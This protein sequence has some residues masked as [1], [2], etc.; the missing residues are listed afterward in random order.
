MSTSI[1]VLKLKGGKWYVGKSDNPLKRYEQHLNGHGSS[2]TK[3]YSPI[4]LE[5]T[6]QNASHFDEDKVTKEYM[7][8]YGIDNV[9]G[10][11]YCSV[12][13]DD[14]Q[15]EVLNREIWGA[16]NKCTR[17]GRST[18]FVKDCYAKTDVNGTTLENEIWCCETCDTEFE[19][20]N[21]CEKHEK[22]CK[23]RVS[24]F[25]CGREG[26]ISTM[27]YAKTH[28]RGYYLR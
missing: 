10:G 18:H 15:M 13:L 2:W 21:E 25:R 11:S 8:K 19:D 22:F 27:C 1:Y 28:I 7:A 20:K 6:I 24:C 3:L 23:K 12:E 4:S 26:H 17:C 9:R 14:F 16:Q 5:K